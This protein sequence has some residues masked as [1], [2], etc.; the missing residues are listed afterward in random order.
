VPQLFGRDPVDAF[1]EHVWVAP[2]YED[3]MRLLRDAMGV[4]HLL[5]GSDWPHP[6]GLREPRA[7]LTDFGVLEP[8]EQRRVLRENLRELS[9]R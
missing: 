1:R 2:F 6:E 9:G 4:E 8:D 3:D 5:L 7:A